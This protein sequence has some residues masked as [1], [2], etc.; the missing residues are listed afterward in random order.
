MTDTELYAALY[1]KVEGT[2]QSEGRSLGIEKALCVDL[3]VCPPGHADVLALSHETDSILFLKKAYLTML[4]RPIDDG[5][6]AS[7]SKQADQ[8]VQDY[9]SGIISGLKGSA[10]FVQSQT[11]L[12]HNIYADNAPYAEAPVTGRFSSVPLPERLLRFYRKM[13]EPMKKAAKKIL[14]TT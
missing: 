4:Q 12:E 13:P 11:I 9:Q 14:G 7:I 5:A 8:P 10:E 2:M 3:A 6:L 1:D